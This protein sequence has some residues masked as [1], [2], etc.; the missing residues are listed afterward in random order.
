MP[1]APDPGRSPANLARRLAA[2]QHAGQDGE[3]SVAGR[4]E[5]WVGHL[6]GQFGSEHQPPVRRVLDPE[7]DVGGGDAD[8]RLTR[9]A[10]RATRSRF[11][12]L[13]E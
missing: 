2:L 7:P 9:R 8:E 13:S 1:Q 12:R 3:G 11:Q 4:L 10:P 5:R 6:L